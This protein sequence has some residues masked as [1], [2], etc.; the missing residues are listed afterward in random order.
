MAEEWASVAKECLAALISL[1]ILCLAAFMVVKVFYAGAEPQPDLLGYNRQK[2]V[3]L[4]I[5]GF[6][7][8]V[9]G[10][11]FGRVPAEWRAQKAEQSATNSQ[12]QATQA[13]EQKAQLAE[14]VRQI[15]NSLGGESQ[16]QRLTLGSGALPPAN[17]DVIEKTRDA[18]DDLLNRLG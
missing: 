5:L 17:L 18:L 6:L 13:K 12:D 1:V 16:Q 7:T 11:Y 8:T 3:M 9:T 14:G 10:Y 4:L 2:D 15:K